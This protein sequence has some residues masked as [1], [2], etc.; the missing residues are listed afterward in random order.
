MASGRQVEYRLN[1]QSNATQVLTRDSAAANKFDNSMWQLQKTMASFGVGLGAHF[2][3]DAAKSWTQAAADYEQAMLR[4]RNA[5]NEGFGFFN[6]SFVNSQVDK[7]KTKLQET[8]DA[9]GNFLFKVKNADL[10]SDVKNRLFENLNYVGKVGGIPQEQMDATVRNVGILLGEGVLEARHLRALSYVHPQIVPFLADA[11]GLKGENNA[12][13]SK[14]LGKDTSDESASQMLSQLI[15]SGKLTKSALNSNLILEAFEKYRLSIESKLPETLDLV[16]SHLNDLSNTWERFKNSLVLGEKSELI[17][18]F[19]SLKNGISWL[20]ENKEEIVKTGKAV[21]DIVKLYAEWRVAL[22]AM[23]L[24]FGI[25][26][27]F[28]NE[29][30]RLLSTI[31]LY[32]PVAT[33][34][35]SINSVLSESN[36]AFAESENV[37]TSSLNLSTESLLSRE[38]ELQKTALSLQQ[39]SVQTDLYTEAQIANLGASEILTE[40]Y[41]NE[42][43]GLK[44]KVFWQTEN[45]QLLQKSVVQMSLF[46]NSEL[47]LASAMTTVTESVLI[48]NEQLAINAALLADVYGTTNLNIAMAGASMAP[49][50]IASGAISAISKAAMPVF[51]AGMAFEVA[52]MFLPKG[53][54]SKD[55][56]TLKDWLKTF[57]NIPFLGLDPF[58]EGAL[59]KAARFG[60]EA[61]LKNHIQKYFDAESGSHT[62]YD[63]L[64]GKLVKAKMNESGHNLFDIISKYQSDAL[65]IGLNLINLLAPANEFGERN[66][67]NLAL[68]SSLKKYGLVSDELYHNTPFNIGNDGVFSGIKKTGVHLKPPSDPKSLKGNSSN[69]FTV[70]I[71]GGLNG[72]TN[73]VFKS[74]DSE[75]MEDVKTMVGVEI[76]R[77]MLQ[78]INDIQ[79][80]H[81]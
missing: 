29:Q 1:L 26:Q 45:Q 64:T 18:F 12:A 47:E 35:A 51:I 39:V 24:P 30:A 78:I 46:T 41:W 42:A 55:E 62:T 71:Y 31:G 21:F 11:L 40:S 19:D 61:G 80:M 2:L 5:S 74:V 63:V 50:Q 10:S 22:I 52:D 77:N 14:L 9:Y 68:K 25:M 15:S 72:M 34:A 70:N 75:T 8:S 66:E 48:Q 59:G 76:T 73:P 43:N 56:T 37:V 69:F 32:I 54:F 33:E 57:G 36:I 58:G 44:N 27:F 3:I 4:I 38:V 17:G 65:A 67:S 79:V 28:A 60:D 81:R 6:E 49:R 23:Q 7:F 13:F 16:Q 20:T 53:A